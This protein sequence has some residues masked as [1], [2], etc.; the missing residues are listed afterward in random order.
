[1][2]VF[3]FELIPGGY[4]IFSDGRLYID[5]PFS[6]GEQG[7]RAMTTE[8]ATAAAEAAIAEL[9]APTVT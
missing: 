1:M 5:Q 6:P 7:K 8:E 9:Q 3:T 4:Q 2:H